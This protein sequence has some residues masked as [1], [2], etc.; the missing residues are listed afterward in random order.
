MDNQ[1][2]RQDFLQFLIKI[3]TDG[4]LGGTWNPKPPNKT[5]KVACL[6]AAT[7]NGCCRTLV[8]RFRC[9]DNATSDAARYRCTLHC[10][11]G[12]WFV[13]AEFFGELIWPRCFAPTLCDCQTTVAGIMAWH[14]M[15]FA[16]T[17]QIAAAH[18]L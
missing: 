18:A 11:A 1:V 3:L 16:T 6:F 14:Q 15:M 5:G 9:N 12:S 13:L 4:C 8:C 7:F 10:A 2:G 17:D